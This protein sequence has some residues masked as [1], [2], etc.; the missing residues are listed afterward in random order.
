VDDKAVQTRFDGGRSV[1]MHFSEADC[2]ER[3]VFV[4]KELSPE[5]WI[6]NG[7]CYSVQV[8]ALCCCAL[9]A[10]A[11]CAAA[12]CVLLRAVCCCALCAAARCAAARCAVLSGPRGGCASPLGP[13]GAAPSPLRTPALP[14]LRVRLLAR[15]LKAAGAEA[16][17]PRVLREEGN[18]SH[19][20][21]KDRCVHVC[22]RVCV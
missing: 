17:L 2:P 10:A 4:L 21:L 6:N 20:S 1:L 13:C 18:A 12:S 8:R 3:I 11:R 19:W 14:G 7:S 9:C 5:Q 16:V 22:V 15:Q